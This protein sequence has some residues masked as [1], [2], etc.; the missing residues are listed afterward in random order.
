MDMYQWILRQ[1]GCLVSPVGY[2]VYVDGLHVGIEGMLN[3]DP[4][5][6]TMSFQT[7]LLNYS[8]DTD[9]VEGVLEKIKGVLHLDHP[10]EHH[11]ECE[12]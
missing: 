12:Y 5:S 2:F 9:W 4:S 8:G 3:S 6:A 10:P 1:K 11:S 7:S